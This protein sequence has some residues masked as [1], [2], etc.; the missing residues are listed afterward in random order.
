MDL[1]SLPLVRP[2]PLSNALFPR[3][4]VNPLLHFTWKSDN[5][6][7]TPVSIDL[8]Y[9]ESVLG[10]LVDVHMVDAESNT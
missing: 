9:A 7:T 8:P 6:S 10:G 2:S 4:V 1:Y 3:P 5:S